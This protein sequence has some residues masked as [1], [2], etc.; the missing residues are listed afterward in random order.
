VT[1]VSDSSPLITLAKIG[2]F[3]LL[4]YLY[5]RVNIPNEVC[6]EVAVDAAGWGRRGGSRQSEWI[7]ARGV[8]NGAGLAEA[9]SDVGLDSV[10]SVPLC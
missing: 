7:E 2:C 9:L 10:R 6:R 5:V 3:D 1:V 8:Q 4:P